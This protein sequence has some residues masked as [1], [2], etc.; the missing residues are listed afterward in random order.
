[1]PWVYWIKEKSID[2]AV[3]GAPVKDRRKVKLLDRFLG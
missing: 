1:M 3:P 2:L